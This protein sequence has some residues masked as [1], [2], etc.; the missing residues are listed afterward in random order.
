[1]SRPGVREHD[2][3]DAVSRAGAI[4]SK[5]FESASRP[6]LG[7]VRLVMTRASIRTRTGW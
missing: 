7:P 6:V 1:M 4:A 3:A 5:P 2:L